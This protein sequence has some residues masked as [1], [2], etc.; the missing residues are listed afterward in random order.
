MR[1]NDKDW[2]LTVETASEQ[3]DRGKLSQCYLN[4]L[5]IRSQIIHQ[6]CFC[7]FKKIIIFTLDLNKEISAVHKEV[8]MWQLAPSPRN[9]KCA[10]N[11]TLHLGKTCAI[12]QQRAAGQR[13]RKSAQR[14]RVLFNG[15]V[16]GYRLSDGPSGP[17]PFTL[18]DCKHESLKYLALSD[19]FMRIA[20]SILGQERK[21]S[22]GGHITV[23]AIEAKW[24][25]ASHLRRPFYRS[26]H[27]AET[28]RAAPL[29]VRRRTY[30]Q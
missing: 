20:L 26:H 5:W 22:V 25:R 2:T 17:P 21:Y 13:T 1:E 12:Q 19:S 7:A 10:L 30:L 18:S 14:G 6:H 11:Q 4:R 3:G 27:S 9:A 15:V 28:L 8:K 29:T 24:S 23:S 16:A